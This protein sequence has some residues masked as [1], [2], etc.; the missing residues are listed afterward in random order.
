MARLTSA[1][2]VIFYVGGLRH[3]SDAGKGC[4]WAG[5]AWGAMGFFYLN[6]P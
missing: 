6:R 2:K 5:V 1:S 3:L 4:Y